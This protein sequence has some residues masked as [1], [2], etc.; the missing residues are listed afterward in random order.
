MSQVTWLSSGW[1]LQGSIGFV[2][3]IKAGEFGSNLMLGLLLTIDSIMII[4]LVLNYRGKKKRLKHPTGV[5]G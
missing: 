3:V 5:T 4:L 1:A 2:L